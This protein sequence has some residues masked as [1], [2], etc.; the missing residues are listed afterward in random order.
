MAC[1]LHSDSGPDSSVGRDSQGQSR[2]LRRFR[3]LRLERGVSGSVAFVMRVAPT[4]TLG[5]TLPAVSHAVPDA[6]PIAA[7]AGGRLPVARPR[8]HRRGLG[9]RALS[10]GR[11]G[12]VAP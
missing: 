7:G 1:N 6:L 5:S 12:E 3:G 10:A 4:P 11:R 8:G 9:P 2:D